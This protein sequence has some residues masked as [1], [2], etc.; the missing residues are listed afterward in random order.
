MKFTI[1]VKSTLIG[2]FTAGLLLAAFSFKQDSADSVGRYQTSMGEKGM[3][4]ID[5]KT[6][7]YITNTDATNSGWRSGNFSNTHTV[8]KPTKDRS[9]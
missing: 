2:F 5:T 3:V 9:L 4:I 1:D 7:A 8:V 6:G